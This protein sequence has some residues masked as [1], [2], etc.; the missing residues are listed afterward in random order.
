[1]ELELEQILLLVISILLILVGGYMLYKYI[2]EN[3]NSVTVSVDI[4]NPS[5]LLSMGEY[6][7]TTTPIFNYN[8]PVENESFTMII[9]LTS[10]GLTEKGYTTHIELIHQIDSKCSREFNTSTDIISF[11]KDGVTISVYGVKLEGLKLCSGYYHIK[12]YVLVDNTK[13]DFESAKDLYVQ[14]YDNGNSSIVIRTSAVVPVQLR[15]YLS[16]SNDADIYNFIREHYIIKKLPFIKY[17]TNEYE[18]YFQLNYLSD[19]DSVSDF[20]IVPNSVL[21][22]TKSV[23]S[24]VIYIEKNIDTRIVNYVNSEGIHNVFI[25]HSNGELYVPT[26]NGIPYRIKI[27]PVD[28]SVNAPTFVFTIRT[29]NDVILSLYIANNTIET[30]SKN[31]NY[32]KYVNYDDFLGGVDVVFT[33]DFI[34]KFEGNSIIVEIATITS[35]SNIEYKDSVINNVYYI[36]N[37]IKR[38]VYTIKKPE[39]ELTTDFSIRI[40]GATTLDERRRIINNYVYTDKINENDFIS[41]ASLFFVE[42][43]N[44]VIAYTYKMNGE[45]YLTLKA[46]IEVKYPILTISHSVKIYGY[47]R[48]DSTNGRIYVAKDNDISNMEVTVNRITHKENIEA[49]VKSTTLY[50]GTSSSNLQYVSYYN[51]Y[52]KIPDYGD[53]FIIQLHSPSVVYQFPE[54]SVEFDYDVATFITYTKGNILDSKINYNDKVTNIEQINSI[55]NLMG[56]VFIVLKNNQGYSYVTNGDKYGNTIYLDYW[57]DIIMIYDKQLIIFKTTKSVYTDSVLAPDS[58][59][60]VIFKNKVDKLYYYSD[61]NI[62]NVASDISEINVCNIEKEGLYVIDYNGDKIY[63]PLQKYS[64]FYVRQNDNIQQFL[65]GKTTKCYPE[66]GKIYVYNVLNESIIPELYEFSPQIYKFDADYQKGTNYIIKS[67][68]LDTKGYPYGETTFVLDDT[69][70]N[71]GFNIEISGNNLG[72]VPIYNLPTYSFSSSYN[73]NVDSNI[74]KFSLSVF[75]STYMPRPNKMMYIL[76]RTGGGNL[77]L[78]PYEEAILDTIYSSSS[79]ANL[80]LKFSLVPPGVYNLHVY[81]VIPQIKSTYKDIKI[82]TYYRPNQLLLITDKLNKITLDIMSYYGYLDNDMF[83]YNDNSGSNEMYIKFFRSNIHFRDKNGMN[84]YELDPIPL[85]M[86]PPYKTDGG[87]TNNG[88]VIIGIIQQV[89]VNGEVL[90]N[91]NIG[92]VN[93]D[94]YITDIEALNKKSTEVYSYQITKSNMSSYTKSLINGNVEYKI[95]TIKIPNEILYYAIE[96]TYSSYKTSLY[97]T[98]DAYDDVGNHKLRVNAKLIPVIPSNNIFYEPTLI[99]Y[100]SGVKSS[101]LRFVQ[102]YQCEDCNMNDKLTTIRI[103]SDYIPIYNEGIVFNYNFNTNKP[104]IPIS[105]ISP[106]SFIGSTK[107]TLVIRTQNKRNYF[108]G[109]NIYSVINRIYTIDFYTISEVIP[110][111]DD[112]IKNHIESDRNKIPS[113][114]LDIPFANIRIYSFKISS[115]TYV[116]ITNE[117]K[118]KEKLLTLI[119]IQNYGGVAKTKISVNGNIIEMYLNINGDHLDIYYKYNKKES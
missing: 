14:G 95:V 81:G 43:V 66:S 111:I 36:S 82:N 49:I 52:A 45:K 96:E 114:M 35:E 99:V 10:L 37:N 77:V 65:L 4:V 44:E 48:S 26:I 46:N 50:V 47:A 72:I 108:L 32:V 68:E 57:K 90:E 109:Y 62:V 100:S 53:N 107:G 22:I 17:E 25:V 29:S 16:L 54:Q 2:I 89:K 116:A 58:D 60:K 6:F 70:K 41:S 11:V 106:I 112:V 93:V 28:I 117:V 56:R 30:M 21:K 87:T 5:K 113:V 80:I 119:N 118:G 91:I 88:F 104:E 27:S 34:D 15:T 86:I 92:K 55:M 83:K 33:Q 76:E 18:K 61:N 94:F 103:L 64:L 98:I 3:S 84:V 115:T 78:I 102:V 71:G 1:M 69:A 74:V 73:I 51:G 97:V 59:G 75:T 39:G 79:Q 31:S 19:S 105:V 42:S 67:D 85:Y 7:K 8:K 101:E 24:K 20:V 12:G 9:D 38:Y 13:V 23:N 40:T 110:S 63:A